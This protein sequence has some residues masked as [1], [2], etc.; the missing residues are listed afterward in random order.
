MTARSRNARRAAAAQDVTVYPV[1]EKVGEELLQRWIVELLRPLI[2]RWLAEKK[3]TALTGADQFVYF[4][5]G[6]T[7]GRVAPDVF[8]LP[9]VRSGRRI[10]S[11]KT[12][13]EHIVPSFALEVVSS[14]VDK[15][16]IEAPTL[17]AELGVEEL[18]IFDPDFE[19]EPDR[20]RFQIYRKL[21]RRGLVRV[22]VTNEDRVFVKVLRCYLR[23]VGSGET[24]RLRLGIGPEGEQLFPTEAEHERAEKERER[25]EKERERAEKERE[26]AEKERERAEKERERAGRLAAEQALKRLQE[27]LGRAPRRRRS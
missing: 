5:R 16:Y 4:R 13:E 7:R 3:V 26:R 22:A 2:E 8:V 19:N 25:A 14:D 12:W 21:P 10:R 11:W 17:Y 27:S 6:D 9:G 23:A 1:E 18:V 20:F 24:T 15:D